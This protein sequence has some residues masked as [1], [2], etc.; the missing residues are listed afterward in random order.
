MLKTVKQHGLGDSGEDVWWAGGGHTDL[1][2]M[3][4]QAKIPEANEQ[5]PKQQKKRM[6]SRSC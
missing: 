1:S 3:H 2:T 4:A 6:K 5:K